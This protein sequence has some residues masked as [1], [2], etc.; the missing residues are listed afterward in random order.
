ML[1]NLDPDLVES[2]C[3]HGRKRASPFGQA[4]SPRMAMEQ[5]ETPILFQL[6]DLGKIMGQGEECAQRGA[7]D[8]TPECDKENKPFFLKY[9]FDE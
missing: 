7:A 8:A 5:L 4:D 3:Q 9:N 1:F 2:A 6:A